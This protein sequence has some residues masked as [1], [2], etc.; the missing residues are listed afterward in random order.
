MGFCLCACTQQKECCNTVLYCNLNVCRNLYYIIKRVIILEDKI[1][2]TMYLNPQYNEG[3]LC[4][5]IA[6]GFYSPLALIQFTP[7]SFCYIIYGDLYCAVWKVA[8][9]LFL[10]CAVQTEVDIIEDIDEYQTWPGWLIICFRTMIMVWFLFELRNTM[11]Y[12]HNTQKL[13]FF[14]HFGASALV[15]FIYLPIIALIALQV[16]ALWRFKLLLG[17]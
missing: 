5:V 13:N 9:N 4:L 12:E 16:S 3:L 7:A 8:Y 17:K 6:H 2:C 1:K 14:L 11:M 10:C 15:W